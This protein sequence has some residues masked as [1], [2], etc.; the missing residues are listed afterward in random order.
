MRT[1]ELKKKLRKAGCYKIREGGNHEIWYSPKTETAFSVGR[2]RNRKQ[3]PEG[4]GAEISPDPTGFSK[5]QES[6][7]FAFLVNFSNPH[8]YPH[9]KTKRSW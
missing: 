7:P 3:N 5:W 8:L 9:S 2:N 1:G 6:E 4:C